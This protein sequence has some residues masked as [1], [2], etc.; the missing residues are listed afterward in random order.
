MKCRP[1]LFLISHLSGASEEHSLLKTFIQ[2]RH[3]LNSNNDFSS[4]YWV[5]YNQSWLSRSK[6]SELNPSSQNHLYQL[7]SAAQNIICAPVCCLFCSPE[8]VPWDLLMWRKQ[9][10]AGQPHCDCNMDF[11]CSTIGLCSVNCILK[12]VNIYMALTQL[13]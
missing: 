5:G 6:V 9:T 4:L 2:V 10:P 12:N 1:V 3:A 8:N 11:S 7:L 13:P